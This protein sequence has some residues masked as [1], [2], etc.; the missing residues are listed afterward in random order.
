MYTFKGK[1]AQFLLFEVRFTGSDSSFL[2]VAGPYAPG[3]K[4]LRIDKAGDVSGC[5]YKSR[6]DMKQLDAQVRE[7]LDNLEKVTSDD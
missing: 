4:R 5:Y 6:L 2:G 3:S 1:K 7:Y